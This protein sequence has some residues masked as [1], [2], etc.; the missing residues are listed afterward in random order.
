MKELHSLGFASGYTIAEHGRKVKVWTGKSRIPQASGLA[1][2]RLEA[3]DQEAG[4]FGRGSVSY[5]AMREL[6]GVRLRRATLADLERVLE[7][8]R[9]SFPAPWPREY[10]VQHVGDDGFVVL[11][12]EG[13]IVGYTIVGV[14]IPSFL[15]R[16]ERRT[17][18]LLTGQEPEELPPVGHIL[19]IAVDPA[20]RRQ[21]LGRRLLEYALDYCRYLGAEQVELEVR[22]NNAAA[23]QLYQKYGF[24]IRERVPYYY[25]DG[26][27]AF[28]M[29]KKL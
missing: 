11:E 5:A 2:L 28:V 19:N 15:A 22:T 26:E 27:D 17:R 7:I 13:L 8:E 25:S 4:N 24:V 10:L 14:K 6:A 23:I 3:L 18:A 29:V 21:G 9:F 12:Y 20:F 16:L 1:G